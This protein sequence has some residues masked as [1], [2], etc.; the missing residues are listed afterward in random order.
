MLSVLIEGI[1]KQK[2]TKILNL[3]RTKIGKL[4]AEKIKSLFVNTAP[5]H[6]EELRIEDC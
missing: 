6:F 1:S 5:W 4:S 2:K 3:K